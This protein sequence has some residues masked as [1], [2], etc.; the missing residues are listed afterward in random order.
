MPDIVGKVAIDPGWGHYELKSIVRGFTDTLA[1]TTGRALGYA[2]GAAATM[3]IV[4]KFVDL[5]LSGLAGYGIGTYGSGQLP[6]VAF[7]RNNSL[8]AIPE[9]QGLVGIISHPWMG[10]DLYLYGGWEHADRAGSPVATSGYGSGAW[11]IRAAIR[12]AAAARPRRRI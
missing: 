4:P 8:M 7:T 5:Q 3:P 6:D 12:W 9:A 2:G 11:S 1:G 10:N